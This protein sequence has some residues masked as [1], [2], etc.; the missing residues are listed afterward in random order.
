MPNQKGSVGVIAL[1]ILIL[2]IAAGSMIYF[3]SNKTPET[4][5]PTPS[6]S[7]E[8]IPSPTATVS[9]TPSPL[10][11]PSDWK[12]YTN[13]KFNFSMQYP[14]TWQYGQFEPIREQGSVTFTGPEGVLTI[15]WGQ[16][17]YYGDRACTSDYD[18]TF[19]NTQTGAG[20]IVL[21]KG[22]DRGIEILVS[23]FHVSQNANFRGLYISGATHGSDSTI[24]TILSTFK[25]IDPLDTTGWKTY[26]SDKYGYQI[27]YPQNW[28][29][30]EEGN[31]PGQVFSYD[32]S[33]GQCV[34]GFQIL[35]M[36]DSTSES[37]IASYRADREAVETIPKV[38]VAGLPAVTFVKFQ[39]DHSWLD[40]TIFPQAS[41]FFRISQSRNTQ[42]PQI[43]YCDRTFNQI[44]STFK[45]TK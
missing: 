14:S 45:F 44:L 30:K 21:C 8:A 6:Q 16:E 33:S 17:K 5:P 42:S 40:I 20:I 34:C 38:T 3:E 11:I 39:L 10:S 32:C 12:M 4:A 36:S 15:G 27:Q 7:A 43:E 22:D 28:N 13:P 19:V 2:V 26:N 35:A 18:G 24:L 1:V 37:E 25:F 23:D 31:P 9:S 41:S 29:F